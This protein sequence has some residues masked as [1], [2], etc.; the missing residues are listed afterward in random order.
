MPVDRPPA[1]LDHFLDGHFYTACWWRRQVAPPVRDHVQ[2]VSEDGPA[3]ALGVVGVARDAE[4][5]ADAAGVVPLE[6]QEAAAHSATYPAPHVVFDTVGASA[7]AQHARPCT[8][9]AARRAP[10]VPCQAP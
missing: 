3:G 8:L 1:L 10:S 5:A 4:E 6:P 9:K 7:A 2:R